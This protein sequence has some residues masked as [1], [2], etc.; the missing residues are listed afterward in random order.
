MDSKPGKQWF[1]TRKSAE[2]R[3]EDPKALVGQQIEIGGV[4]GVVRGVVPRLGGS[5]LHSIEMESGVTENVQVRD[6]RVTTPTRAGGR[7]GGGP[8]PPL[9]PP[10]HP[11]VPS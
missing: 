11:S 8:L 7:A 4:W 3:A 9:P 10:A 6:T 5:T 1:N 2:M